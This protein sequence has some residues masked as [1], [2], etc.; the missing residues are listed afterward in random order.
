MVF[1]FFVDFF[2]YCF[3]TEG[4]SGGEGGGDGGGSTKK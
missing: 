1:E 2:S 4:G 3:L